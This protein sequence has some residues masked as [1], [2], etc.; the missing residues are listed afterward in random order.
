[1]DRINQSRPYRVVEALKEVHFQLKGKTFSLLGLAFKPNTDDVREAVSLKVARL[2][3]EEG[4]L[5][6]GYD[7]QAGHF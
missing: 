4:A 6:K 1:M 3:I 2:L 7:P 5:L